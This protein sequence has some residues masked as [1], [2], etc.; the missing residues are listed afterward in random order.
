LPIL[1]EP[2]DRDVHF[3]QLLGHTDISIEFTAAL[4]KEGIPLGLIFDISHVAQ[5]GEDLTTAWNMARPCCDHVH[6]ANCVLE[7]GNP[8]YGDRHPFFEIP[9][10]V[11]SHRDARDFLALLQNDPGPLTVSLEMICP[12][13]EKEDDF[14]KRLTAETA[15]YFAL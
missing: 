12:A 2:G 7:K 13:G 5:L 10:G 6:F 9:Q 8:L 1:L 3:R 14:F 4:R 15:W 11:Y